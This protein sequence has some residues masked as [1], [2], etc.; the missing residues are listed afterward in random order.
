MSA[1]DYLATV[2]GK[3]PKIGTGNKPIKMDTDEL[4]RLLRHAFEA[5][6]ASGKAEKSL[7]EQ[8]FGKS[9]I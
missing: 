9:W 5:G 2:R 8:V 7:F 1:D 4:F 6:K 3:T